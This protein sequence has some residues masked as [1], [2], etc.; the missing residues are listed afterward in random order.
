MSTEIYLG[1]QGSTRFYL[2]TIV[3]NNYG[4]IPTKM[5]LVWEKT[6]TST[7][8]HDFYYPV[9]TTSAQIMTDLTSMANGN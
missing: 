3:D 2:Q 1:S 7:D 8:R 4:R 9:D 5:A 6:S